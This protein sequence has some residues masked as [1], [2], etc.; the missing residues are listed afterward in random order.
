[1]VVL[2]MFRMLC[3]VLCNVGTA[4]YRI[5]IVTNTPILEGSAGVSRGRLLGTH[6]LPPFL[7]ANKASKQARSFDWFIPIHVCLF[8]FYYL[9]FSKSFLRSDFIPRD[10][11][12]THAWSSQRMKAIEIEWMNL[13][14]IFQC[15]VRLLYGTEGRPPRAVCRST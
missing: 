12:G 14:W 7:P 9:K 13:F 2:S 15:I 1:M 5:K 4:S 11:M 8:L 10:E 6:W 3:W